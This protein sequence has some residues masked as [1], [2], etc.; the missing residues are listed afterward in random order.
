MVALALVD[1]VAGADAALDRG[2]ARFGLVQVQRAALGRAGLVARLSFG[3]S[4]GVPGRFEL[5]IA[6]AQAVRNAVVRWRNARE[7]GVSLD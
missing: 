6:G 5:R 4:C 2:N 1:P 7:V 3:D